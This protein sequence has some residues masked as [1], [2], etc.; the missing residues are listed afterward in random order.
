MNQIWRLNLKPEPDKGIEPRDVFEFCQ[1]NEILG[2]GWRDISIRTD[3][4]W[5]LKSHI[6]AV[7]SEGTT[8][9]L[10]AINAM[11]EMSQDDLVYTR[12]DGRYYLCRVMSKW[13][14]NIPTDEHYKYDVFNYVSVEWADIGS[15]AD[16]PGKVINSF[17]PS[18]TVQRVRDVEN[19]SKLL[20]NMYAKSEYRYAVGSLELDGFWQSINS[21]DLECLVLLYLQ[22]RG[23]YVYSST[24]KYST[25]KIECVMVKHDG[26]HKC[27]PQVKRETTL[28]AQD[29]EVLLQNKEDKVF[30]FT[31]SQSFFKNENTQFEYI[32]LAEIEDFIRKNKLNNLLPAS[33]LGWVRICDA[34]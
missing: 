31:S 26:S 6:E 9:A 2:V 30:L 16:V 18:A 10:K 34:F 21:E 24:L 7:Y 12:F 27:Y 14:D 15:E 20:W 8:R 19:I 1:G 32:T 11:R 25:A 5:E 17:G 22:S 4:Y 23:Y 29:Y 3:D 33:V 28:I 13:V